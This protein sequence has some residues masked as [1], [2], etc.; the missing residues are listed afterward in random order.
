MEFGMKTTIKGAPAIVGSYTGG[1]V[2][3][4]MMVN[5]ITDLE[6]G[7]AVVITDGVIT[8]RWDGSPLITV[9]DDGA[10]NLTVTQVTLGVVTTKQMK[11]DASVSALRLGAYLRDRVVL[12]DDSALT[13]ANEFT[14]SCVQLFAEGAW[15]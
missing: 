3:Q 13:A 14:L 8:G 5:G 9:Q 10:G 1:N 4:Q 7:H 6:P 15:L 2:I 12:A 11:G